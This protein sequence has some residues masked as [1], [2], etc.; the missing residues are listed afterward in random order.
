VAQTREQRNAYMAAYMKAWYDR[1]RAE[2][3]A[4]LGGQCVRCG[5]TE[6]LEIDHKDPATV[7]RRMR[8]G[9]GGMWTAS[10]ERFQAELAKCQ[11]LCHSCHRSKTLED[12]GFKPAKGTHGTLSAY[13]YCGPPKCEEC[14][15]AKR[16]YAQQRR[17]ANSTGQSVSLLRKR[18]G[19]R[20]PG[21]AHELREL[22]SL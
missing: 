16:E 6:N 2:A 11:L 22:I 3:I 9:R 10:E 8:Q 20:I 5:T 17:A 15:A 19:V 21:G 14:K 4:K 12:R 13:R 1:R 18:F 7:D